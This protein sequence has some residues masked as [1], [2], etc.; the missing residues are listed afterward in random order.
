[1]LVFLKDCLEKKAI[2][3]TLTR[4]TMGQQIA[5]KVEGGKKILAEKK[6]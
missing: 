5:N 4:Q 1:M 3:A 2:I 6:E